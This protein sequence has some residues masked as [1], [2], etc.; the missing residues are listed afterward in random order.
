VFFGFVLFFVLLGFDL[1][2]L[3]L[4]GKSPSNPFFFFFDLYGS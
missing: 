3:S 1:R 2:A 4:L